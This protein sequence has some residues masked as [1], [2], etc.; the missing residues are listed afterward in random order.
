MLTPLGWWEG[1]G[2]SLRHSLLWS[3][4]FFL[5]LLIPKSAWPI[6]SATSASEHIPFCTRRFKS[7]P[8]RSEVPSA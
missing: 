6:R 4:Q 7:V 8:V 5:S 2:P 1:A 3:T